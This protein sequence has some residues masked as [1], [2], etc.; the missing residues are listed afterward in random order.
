MK[1]LWFICVLALSLYADPFS[2]GKNCKEI[3]FEDEGAE[4]SM[5]GYECFYPKLP[6]IEAYKKFKSDSV[7]EYPGYVVFEQL[8]ADL[9][10]GKSYTD[11]GEDQNGAIVIQYDW[12]ND[13]AL[14][15]Y[16]DYES[17]SM[18]VQFAQMNNGTRMKVT[19]V[20]D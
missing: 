1:G 15:V 9:E 2:D 14:G 16:A 18:S 17:G 5:E 20:S 8:R 7:E 3:I 19:F 13:K 12:D 11:V 10:I 4:I 6:L